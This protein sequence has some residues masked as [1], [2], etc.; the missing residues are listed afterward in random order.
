MSIA[1]L[2]YALDGLNIPCLGILASSRASSCIR[3]IL[4]ERL[5]IKG[6]TSQRHDPACPRRP[7]VAIERTSGTSCPRLGAPVL[8]RN[9]DQKGGCQLLLRR[10]SIVAALGSSWMI[11]PDHEVINTALSGMVRYFS[12]TAKADHRAVIQR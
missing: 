5:R 4:Y 8:D 9:L 3:C 10:A 2:L 1:A 6:S 12:T 7:G 11:A